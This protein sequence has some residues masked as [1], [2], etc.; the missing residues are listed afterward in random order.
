[1][2]LFKC[3]GQVVK[4]IEKL[5]RDFLWQGREEKRKF[6]LVNWSQVCM[7]KAEGS[8]G[9]RPVKEVNVALLGKWLWRIKDDSDGLW[10]Q[11]LSSKY[12]IQ[13]NG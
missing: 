11:I 4:G 6:H 12:N 13:R 8:L 3:P 7:P 2:S 9:I 10:K 5:Q 1:M